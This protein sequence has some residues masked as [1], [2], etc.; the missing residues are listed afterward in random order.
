MIFEK[1]LMSAT[2]IKYEVAV[3]DVCQFAVK[4]SSPIS[5]AASAVG[6]DGVLTIFTVILTQVVVSQSPSALT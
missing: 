1:S 6:A 4:Y 2:C 5:V 3:A